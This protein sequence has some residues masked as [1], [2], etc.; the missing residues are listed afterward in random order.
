MS[1]RSSFK[2]IEWAIVTIT[3]T[4]RLVA[5]EHNCLS[6]VLSETKGPNTQALT[7]KEEKKGDKI[8]RGKTRSHSMFHYSIK[9]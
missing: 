3:T 5:A 9:W 1:G 4:H 6:T 7:L 2:C 8:R